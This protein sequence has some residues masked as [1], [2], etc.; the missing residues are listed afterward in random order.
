MYDYDTL[1]AAMAKLGANGLRE[2][3]RFLVATYAG[4]DEGPYDDHVVWNALAR[5]DEEEQEAMFEYL[6]ALL[7]PEVPLEE[8]TPLVVH[9]I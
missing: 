2:L 4:R 6:F 3:S 9:C 7:M 1:S 5:L 8:A